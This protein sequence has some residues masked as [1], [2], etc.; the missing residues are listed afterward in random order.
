M[1]NKS[2][3]ES[4][5]LI[6]LFGS[7]QFSGNS[8]RAK[9]KNE[10]DSVF[11]CC[12]CWFDEFCVF[13]AFV[14]RVR[15]RVRVLLLLVL[16]LLLQPTLGAVVR[17]G[18]S[19]ILKN[20][21]VVVVV[22]VVV[23]IVVV[24]KIRLSSFLCVK[25]KR[26]RETLKA[27]EETDEQQAVKK[28]FGIKRETRS[29]HNASQKKE[30]KFRAEKDDAHTHTHTPSSIVYTFLLSL[31]AGRKN[32]QYV[33]HQVSPNGGEERPV[34]ARGIEMERPRRVCSH[35]NEKN[36]REETTE[37]RERERL[38]VERSGGE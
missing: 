33:H 23:L 10:Y 12:C 22:V 15:V 9:P 35:A 18:R 2:R 8:A 29:L 24:E 16:Q 14:L 19:S 1:M 37:I 11:A 38:G 3:G 6:F 34:R 20:K 36:E 28:K 13:V 27:T 31:F 25:K 32:T 5:Y 7:S 21:F 4:A 17:A 30:W 26:E